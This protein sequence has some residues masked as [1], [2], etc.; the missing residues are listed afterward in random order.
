MGREKQRRSVKQMN[1]VQ[2]EKWTIGPTF[3][4][5]LN[6]PFIVI[7]IDRQNRLGEDEPLL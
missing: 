6:G 1:Q 7:I 2:L 5:G 3:Y 4:E